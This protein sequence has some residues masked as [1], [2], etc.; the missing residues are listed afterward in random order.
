MSAIIT[1]ALSSSPFDSDCD[2]MVIEMDAAYATVL[3]QLM[4]ECVKLTNALAREISIACEDHNVRC[5]SSSQIDE[6][7]SWDFIKNL[8]QQGSAFLSD[9]Q[10]K[11]L[12]KEVESIEYRNANIT[13]KCVEWSCYEREFQVRSILT[14][15]RADI[16]RWA[17]GELCL[18]KKS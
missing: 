3:L 9:E 12:T 7:F 14:V 16:E 13:G 4:D 18:Q 1:S 15:E 2:W 8:E 11:L 10:S 17:K 5:Y 6:M